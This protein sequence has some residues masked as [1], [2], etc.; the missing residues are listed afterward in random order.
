MDERL[1]PGAA[2]G[3]RDEAVEALDCWFATIPGAVRLGRLAAKDYRRRR[4]SDGWRAPVAFPSGERRL[5]TLIGDGFPFEVPRIALVDRPPYLTWPHVESD[6][7]LCLPTDQDMTRIGA[8]VEIVQQL[9]SEAATLVENCERG[10]NLDDFRSEFLSY[11]RSDAD[12]PRVYSLLSPPERSGVAFVHRLQGLYVVADDQND[13]LRWLDH[14]YPARHANR[15]QIDRRRV[16]PVLLIRTDAP[17]APSEYPTDSA[18]IIRLVA[19]AG[20][21]AELQ[22]MASEQWQRIVVLF[23]SSTLR[24]PVFAAAVLK[25]RATSRFRPPLDVE[26]GFRPGR[27]PPPIKAR[28]FLGS[29]RPFKA[30]V[31]RVDAS[32]IHGRDGDPDLTT[33]RAA[34]V[35]MVGCGS[36]GSLVAMALAQAGVGALD[37]LDPQVLAAAN[38]GRHALGV[39]EINQSK[40]KALE[41]LLRSDYPHMLS[42]RGHHEEWQAFAHREPEIFASADLIISSIGDFGP[43]A[44]L[45]DWRRR[46]S[47][48]PDMLFGWTE[49]YAVAGHAVGLIGE[50]G[51][52]G[53]GLN[54]WGEPSLPVAAWPK[55]T[56]RRGEPACGVMF[57]PYGPTELSHVSALIAEAAID[58]LLGRETEPFNRVWIA[59]EQI[60]AR[61]GG[62]WSEAWKARLG[63]QPRGACVEEFEW[64]RRDDC[65]FC[66]T[67]RR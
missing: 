27:T 46:A 36:I 52:L 21:Q 3:R 42:V 45:N 4:F 20:L 60:I 34:R 43:E 12:A 15:L 37:L 48:R 58:I 10:E 64:A 50:E 53:C 54:E 67:D 66:A 14:A 9:L 13:L 65:P 6:G 8:S 56:G 23:A 62:V 32:W 59:R 2:T 1:A 5:D 47:G 35:V 30:A 29:V 26:H 18:D 57:Q 11:W 19:G 51:C 63:D 28:R 44:A 17:L 41:G 7:V 16:D 25:S 31:E 22:R 24:G 55:G 40:S 39:A 33:L 61:A 38:V 49:P